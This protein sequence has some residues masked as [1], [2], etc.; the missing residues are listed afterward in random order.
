MVRAGAQTGVPAFSV[1]FVSVR[2]PSD[3]EV[4]YGAN[5]THRSAG[6][7]GLILLGR[8]GSL[9]GL[10]VNGIVGVILLFLTNLVLADDIPIN[11]ITILICAIGG[12]VGYLVIL[13]L[14]V[15]GIAFTVAV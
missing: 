6:V 10:V 1:C 7:G 8:G 2:D 14:H 5:R 15:L 9:M 13:V 3:K 11:L 12:V 4:L